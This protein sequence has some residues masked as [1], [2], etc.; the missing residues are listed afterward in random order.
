MRREGRLVLWPAYF[1]A[2][3]SWRQGRRVPRALAL[4]GVKAEEIFHAALDLGLNPDLRAGMAH[5][6]RPWRKG[7]AVLVDKAGS[8]TGIVRAIAQRA[9]ERRRHK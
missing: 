8:K 4:R 7:G 1:D 2:D 3:S 5:P 6:K 9:R